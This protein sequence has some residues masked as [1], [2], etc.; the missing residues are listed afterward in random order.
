MPISS[1]QTVHFAVSKWAAI[2]VS[3]TTAENSSECLSSPINPAVVRV[4]SRELAVVPMAFADEHL[5]G[6]SAEAVYWAVSSVSRST[7]AVMPAVLC[8]ANI[9]GVNVVDA[10]PEPPSTAAVE[11]AN[12][13]RESMEEQTVWTVMCR[14]CCCAVSGGKRLCAVIVNSHS[15]CSLA[16]T[17]KAQSL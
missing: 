4:P 13:P 12:D 14:E 2:S 17:S 16:I 15:V 6:F 5:N 3:M 9:Y 11:V 10:V 1:V 7:K 8:S